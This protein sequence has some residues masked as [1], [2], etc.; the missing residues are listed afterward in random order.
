MTGL[1]CIAMYIQAQSVK[2]N[3]GAACAGMEFD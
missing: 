1:C 3:N 2:A